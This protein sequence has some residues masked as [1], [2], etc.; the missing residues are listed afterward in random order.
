MTSAMHSVCI[1]HVMAR[2]KMAS[3]LSFSIQPSV[4]LDPFIQAL[5]HGPTMDNHKFEKQSHFANEMLY[6]SSSLTQQFVLSCLT[7]G[8]CPALRK[9]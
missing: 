1:C 4:A 3:R 8:A 2:L 6:D 7:T 5:V 9:I